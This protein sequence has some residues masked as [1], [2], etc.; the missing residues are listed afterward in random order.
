[1]RSPENQAAMLGRTEI[2]HGHGMRSVGTGL[3]V[4]GFTGQWVIGF[5]GSGG[6]C[7]KSR[8]GRD[9]CHASR[10]ALGRILGEIWVLS[11]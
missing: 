11:L 6:P 4:P 1:M 3:T 9:L 5:P 7:Q 10:E 8:K 2:Q